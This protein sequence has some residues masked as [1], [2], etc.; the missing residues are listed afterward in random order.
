MT[1]QAEQYTTEALHARAEITDR[2]HLY[3]H[4]VDRRRWDLL[5]QVF[6]P[7]ATWWVSSIGTDNHWRDAMESSR[8]L[9]AVA[10]DATHHQVGNILISLDGA[11]ADTEALIT[12]YHRVRADAP[13]GGMFGGTGS[14]YDLF[15]G[16]RYLDRWE[17]RDGAW[18]IARR[19]VASE[20]RHLQPASDGIL[21]SVPLQARGKYDDTDLS[22]PTIERFRAARSG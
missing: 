9:F 5:D 6:H 14:P 3:A 20:W 19:R 21:A 18:K 22:T 8:E 16:G 4:C 10:L 11:A 7:D 15:A 12:A 17:L 1:S 2:F 13:L